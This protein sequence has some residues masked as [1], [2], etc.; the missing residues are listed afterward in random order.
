MYELFKPRI[1]RE[2]DAKTLS[3]CRCENCG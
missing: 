2:Q 3:L 1:S